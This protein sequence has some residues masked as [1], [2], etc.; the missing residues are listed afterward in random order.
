[1]KP[2][3]A[4]GSWHFGFV[5][6]LAAIGALEGCGGGSSA[7]PPVATHLLVTAPTATIVAGKSFSITVSAVDNTG[8][9]VSSV[10]TTVH[11]AS[12]DPQAV[13]PKDSPLTNGT[14]TFQVTLK[15]AGNQ[16][17]TVSDTTSG[18]TSGTLNSLSVSSGAANRFSVSGPS[19]ATVSIPINAT[20]T[21]LDD[22]AN[23][24]TSY[25][26]TVHLTSSDAQAVL[27]A[28]ST[29]TSGTGNFSVTL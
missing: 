27:P 6:S 20:V 13:L 26:G 24:V 19:A 10:S 28:N 18:L 3:S 14:G 1:M 5:V 2:N 29:L 11:F 16:T 7:P 9:V 25:S 23:V 17:A 15:T 22:F 8:A 12:S 21:A 4:L